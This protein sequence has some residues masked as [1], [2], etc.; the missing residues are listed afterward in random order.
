MAL[1][2]VRLVLKLLPIYK[3][4]VQEHCD[5]AIKALQVLLV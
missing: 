1:G 3:R 5:L 4:L 2:L